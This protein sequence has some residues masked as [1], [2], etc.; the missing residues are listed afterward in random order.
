MNVIDVFRISYFK[1]IQSCYYLARGQA[2]VPPDP[3]PYALG[4]NFV[5][6]EVPQSMT[7]HTNFIGYSNNLTKNSLSP[8]TITISN[9]Y[10]TFNG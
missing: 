5:G 9:I 10:S 7:F 3:P 4:D 8:G 2:A 1:D 6:L